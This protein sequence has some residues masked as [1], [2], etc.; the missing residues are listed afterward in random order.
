MSTAAPREEQLYQ[1]AGAMV[2]SRYRDD[3]AVSNAVKAYNEYLK[4]YEEVAS[5]L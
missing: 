4:Q 2:T 5:T 1:I 3:Q